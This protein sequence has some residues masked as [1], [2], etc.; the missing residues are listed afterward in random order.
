ML[1]LTCPNCGPRNAAEFRHGGEVHPRPS[2][3]AEVAED[4]W[5]DFL[6][7][8]RNTA[9]QQTEWWYHRLGCG[10]WFLAD[11]HNTTNEV[12]RTYFWQPKDTAPPSEAQDSQLAGSQGDVSGGG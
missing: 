1:L 5:V 6:Y 11:R 7:M 2:P 12:L 8:K 10:L 3:E 4:D 9:G